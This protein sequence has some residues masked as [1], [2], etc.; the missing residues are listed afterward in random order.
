VRS[1]LMTGTA[2][3]EDEIRAT[4]HEI[5]DQDISAFHG[6]VELEC[7]DD[8]MKAIR[9]LLLGARCFGLGRGIQ[10]GLISLIVLVRTIFR[11]LLVRRYV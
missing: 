3:Y 1:P 8:E 7:V 5:E 10:H 6:A 11:R 4:L 2:D 9:E